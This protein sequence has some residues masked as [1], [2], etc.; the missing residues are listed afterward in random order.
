MIYRQNARVLEILPQLK[1]RG[2]FRTYGR[3]CQNQNSCLHR[4]L[5]FLTHGAPLRA[6]RERY[7]KI[8]KIR[9]W[10]YIFQRHFMR[11]LHAEGLMYGGKFA[12]QIDWA[13][14]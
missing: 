8:P 5:N 10:A 4:Q 12:F 6:L 7:R 9:P 11:G 3:F 2:G 1:F 13:S 14:L